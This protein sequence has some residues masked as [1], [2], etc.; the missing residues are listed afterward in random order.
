MVTVP[1][2]PRAALERLHQACTQA[3]ST[4]FDG[5][6]EAQ[7][8]QQFVFGAELEPWLSALAGRPEQALY[9]IA[10]REYFIA[11][12]NLAQGQYRNAFKGLRL[13]LELHLQGILLSTDPIG[14]S[15]W[16]RNAKDTSWTA[17]VDEEKGVFSPRFAKAFFPALEDRMGAYRG[18]AKA[19]YKELSET[20][21]GNV[22]NAIHLPDSIGFSEDAFATWCEKAETVRS[23]VHFGLTLRYL[24]EFD[25]ERTGLVET[26]LLDRLGSVAAVRER[27]GGPA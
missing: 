15:E 3:M 2:T 19:I 25:G 1:R 4:S 8:A 13:V 5:G 10:H 23:T 7:L 24:S 20:T 22:A 26:M 18:V 11:M 12:L 27:L 6:R 9:E 17:I 14:L 21:H 16:L